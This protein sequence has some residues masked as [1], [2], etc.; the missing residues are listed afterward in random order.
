MAANVGRDRPS[1]GLRVSAQEKKKRV[2][3]CN[4]FEVGQRQTPFLNEILGVFTP[5]SILNNN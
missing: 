1:V 3:V 4:N 2:S 5:R